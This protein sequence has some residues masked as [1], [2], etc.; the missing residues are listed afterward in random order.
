MS[1]KIIKKLILDYTA[2][3]LDRIERLHVENHLK[4]CKDCNQFFIYAK[5]EWRLWEEWEDIEPSG[6]VVNRF[7][8]RIS[9]K[10]LGKGEGIFSIVK[11]F[12]PNWSLIPSLSLVVAVGIASILYIHLS[13]QKVSYTEMDREDEELLFELDRTLST[14]NTNLLEIYGPW[15]VKMIKK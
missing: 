2:D 13:H 14:N 12:I 15:D 7:W 10:E 4:D 1:C 11:S 8:K 6:D 9:E 3:R 5:N